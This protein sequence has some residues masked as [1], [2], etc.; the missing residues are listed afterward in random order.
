MKHKKKQRTFDDNKVA[1]DNFTITDCVV[2]SKARLI[3]SEETLMT[4]IHKINNRE[5]HVEDSKAVTVT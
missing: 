4:I 1:S 3:K 2:F 5:S